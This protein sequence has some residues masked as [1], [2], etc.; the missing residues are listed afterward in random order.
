MG[1]S[2]SSARSAAAQ[3]ERL[4]VEEPR[5]W[6]PPLRRLTRK[7]SAGWECIAFAEEVLGIVLYPWQRWLLVH[8]LELLPDGT[9]R[10]RTVVLLVARQNGKSTLMQVLALWRMYVDGAPLVIGTA[11][12]LDVAEEQWAAAVDIAESVPEL[13]AEVAQKSLVNGKKFL[14]LTSGER[15]K[16]AAASRRGGRGLSGDLVLLDELREHQHWDAWGAVTKTT[17]ARDRAQ[18]WAASNAG[19]RASVVLAYLRTMAH[20]E[21]GNPDGLDLELLARNDDLADVDDATTDDDALGIF[22][23]SAAPA[24][25]IWDRDGW[26]QANPSLG[27][28][29]GVSERAIAAA[30]RTDPEDVFRTEVLCQWPDHAAGKPDLDVD[31][32]LRLADP[33]AARG[34]RPVFGV[35]VGTDRL[36]HIA[37]A[38]KRPDGAVQ[39]MLADTNLSPLATPGRLGK[40]ARDWAGPVMLGGPA[41]YLEGEL[42]AAVTKT[43]VSSAEF[44]SAA[45]R[46]EDLLADGQLRHGNQAP[47]NAS[48]AAARMRP[49]GTAGERT[50]QLKDAPGA[51]P[52][53]ATVRALHGVLTGA[54]IPPAVPLLA[55]KTT[56][57]APSAD[58]WSDEELARRSHRPDDVRFM[59][60]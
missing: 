24:C 33:E 29:G 7:T 26:A 16:V 52:L 45:G 10:F 58:R 4:G 31:A 49:Y 18:V 60:F 53:A 22:E 44:A 47:L 14:K 9:Y 30:A 8:A 23:W 46:F 55:S 17:M 39:V 6:T 3:P 35:D 42:P 57:R 56:P 21:V 12:N 32:W 5:V 28:P 37:V 38:W 2:P 25:G 34:A 20:A 48:V 11:Q 19:D 13:A 54:G 51:G 27:H 59:E 40:L 43:V 15:Y 36:A 50:L 1:S 41:A